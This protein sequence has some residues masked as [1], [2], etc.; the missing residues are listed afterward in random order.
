MGYG[1]FSVGSASRS[2]HRFCYEYFH[3]RIP[4]GLVVRHRCDNPLCVNPWHLETGTHKDNM[5]DRVIRNRSSRGSKNGNAKLTED[6]VLDI[7]H[8]DRLPTQISEDYGIDHTTVRNIKS[9]KNWTH[10]TGARRVQRK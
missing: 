10:L 8:D 3:G 4:E 9:G 2:A 5:L 6:Q 7:F 1:S